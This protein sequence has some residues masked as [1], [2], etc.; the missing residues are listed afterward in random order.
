M[1]WL[2]T[3]P[4]KE[5]ER[6]IADYGL[7]LYSMTELCARYGVSRTC[8]YKWIERADSGTTAR[9]TFPRPSRS[10]SVRRGGPTRAGAPRMLVQ[11]LARHERGVDWPAPSTAGDLP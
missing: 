5:R 4:V 2:E 7:G 8:G 10:G 3:Q 1:P 11:W 6:F 9:T